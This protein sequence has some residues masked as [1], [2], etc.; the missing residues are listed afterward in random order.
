VT[1]PPIAVALFVPTLLWLAVA[2]G[3]LIRSQQTTA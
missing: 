2:S 3:A 1:E